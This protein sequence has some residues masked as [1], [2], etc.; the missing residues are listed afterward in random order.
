MKNR[1]HKKE[2]ADY[3][4]NVVT[5]LN[6][7][8]ITIVVAFQLATGFIVLSADT[9]TEAQCL[10]EDVCTSFDVQDVLVRKVLV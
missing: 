10:I 3:I 4:R 8:A 6:N 7:Q 2:H 9:V 1:I 5:E